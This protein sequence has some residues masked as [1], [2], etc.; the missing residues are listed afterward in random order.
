LSLL[1][2][3]FFTLA[4]TGSGQT[5]REGL[6]KGRVFAG[7][8]GTAHPFLKMDAAARGTAFADGPASLSGG[9]TY[10]SGIYIGDNSQSDVDLTGVP[11]SQS[12]YEL[13]CSTSQRCGGTA[14]I[15]RENGIFEPFI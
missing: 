13:A 5:W 2:L 14:A 12:I 1:H 15:V 10:Y 9:V 4:K 11:G 7:V 8:Y 3:A 6:K